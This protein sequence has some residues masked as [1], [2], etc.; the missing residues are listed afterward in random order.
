MF[1]RKSKPTSESTTVSRR[2][3][4]QAR[5]QWDGYFTDALSALL[6]TDS[7]RIKD[8][9]EEEARTIVESAA[10]IANAALEKIE[11]RFGGI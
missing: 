7:E 4:N 6:S 2:R 11:E 9:G 5:E 3:V 8:I 10:R 1:T